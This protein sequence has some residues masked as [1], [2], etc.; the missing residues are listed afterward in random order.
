[1]FKR[2]TK[3]T[4]LLVA[5][6]SVAST[7]TP[8][9]AADVKR[10]E[11]EDGKIYKAFAYKDGQAYIDGD[12]DG[13]EQVSFYSNGKFN[14]LEDLDTDSDASLYG[15]KYVKVEDGDYFVDLTSGKVTEDE[16]D[17][18]DED[19]AASSLR[20]NIKKDTDDRF[21]GGEA[22]DIQ[23]L[24]LL[25]GEKF[26]DLWF[27][28]ANGIKPA[29]SNKGSL[30]DGHFDVY[31]DKDG[32]YIDADYN[33]GKIKVETTGDSVNVENTKDSVDLNKVKDAIS[34]SLSDTEYLTQDSKYIYRK[35]TITVESNNSEKAGIKSVFG[36]E[37][38]ANNVFKVEESDENGA[39][40]V[41]FDVIQKIS[42]AQASD[43]V[44]GVKYAKDVTNYV[45][46][47]DNGEAQDSGKLDVLNG[48][49]SGYTVADG[50]LVAYSFSGT[51]LQTVT[52]DFGKK[53][54][55]SYTDLKDKADED[56]DAFDI[57]AE[58]NIWRLDGGNIYKWNNDEDWDKVYKV[59]G[60]MSNLSVYDKNNMIVWDEDDEVYSVIGKK[61]EEEKP[62]EETPAVVAGW[63]QAADGTWTYVNADGTTVKGWFQSPASGKWF[64]MDPA[65]GVMQTGWVQSPAS[66]KWFYMN[67]SNG[68]MMTGWVQV[69]TTWYYL[70]PSNGDMQTG[71]IND[72]NAWYYCDA[73]GAML[74]NTTVDG[75][76]LG[77][78]GAWIR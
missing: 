71:W 10:I 42:K 60:S 8:V 66:G 3:I 19:S 56:C 36:I 38:A 51:K 11:S 20:K 33:L 31:T 18:D 9:M 70:N 75:Y 74:S 39:T 67:P 37:V 2:S 77:A 69:G 50:K 40:K 25:S 43:D 34:A 29:G 58:G 63:N 46:S 47:K 16:I 48:D 1:M 23:D 26:G 7:M 27:R 73:S 22:G 65:T 55:L 4:S 53:K 61:V 45:I 49:K 62:V 35:A 30:K 13:K 24:T 54:N 41:S 72:G 44:D 5:A 68:D 15:E 59:D 14:K 76:V 32:K 17:E 57:D 78:N 12:I 6:A 64:Y 52:V 28:V 21:D